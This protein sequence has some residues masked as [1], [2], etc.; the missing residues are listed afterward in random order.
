M[1][2]SS[3]QLAA[4]DPELTTCMARLRPGGAT[5]VPTLRVC[6]SMLC[7]SAACARHLRSRRDS[8]WLAASRSMPTCSAISARCLGGNRLTVSAKASSSRRKLSWSLLLQRLRMLTLQFCSVPTMRPTWM[9]QVT[10]LV[11]E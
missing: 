1:M 8:S 10:E 11:V 6:T 5:Q 7:T 2:A 4:A 9:A 3:P